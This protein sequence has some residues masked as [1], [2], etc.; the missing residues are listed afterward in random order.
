MDS[1]SYDAMGERVFNR[2]SAAEKDALMG[3]LSEAVAAADGSARVG[4]GSPSEKW[5]VVVK[6]KINECIQRRQAEG[7]GLDASDVV[8][9]VLPLAI[10]AIPEE[11]RRGLFIRL[12][13][14]LTA[15]GAQ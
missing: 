8:D 3:Y 15:G 1:S 2:L 9:E 11:V 4:A 5:T 7:E 14:M 10:A 13:K 6:A 12:R